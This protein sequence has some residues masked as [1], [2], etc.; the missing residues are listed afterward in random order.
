MEV[1]E[2]GSDDFAEGA[3]FGRPDFPPFGTGRDGYLSGWFIRE[4]RLFF[5][6]FYG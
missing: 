6:S 3:D 1:D 4:R 5:I 2:S